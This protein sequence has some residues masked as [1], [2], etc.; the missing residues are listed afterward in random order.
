M[1]DTDEAASPDAE[2]ATQ[3]VDNTALP[4]LADIQQERDEKLT[5]LAGGDSPE[6]EEEDDTSED[7]VEDSEE[8]DEDVKD[9]KESA[10][11]VLSKE[12]FDA[13]S[14]EDKEAHLTELKEVTGAAFGKQRK[15]IRELKQELEAEKE[16]NKAT[17]AVASTSDSPFGN[18]HTVEQVDSS[19]TAVEENIEKYRDQMTY[20]SVDQ[21]SEKLE[22]D[23]RGIMVNG[24]FVSSEK[25]KS[26]VQEQREGITKLK[27]RKTEIRKVAKLFDDEDTEIETLKQSLNMSEEEAAAFE[28]HIA[29]PSFAVIKSVRPEYAKKLFDI[30]A[31]ASI[32]D[33]KPKTRKAPKAQNESASLPKGSN[34]SPKS[35]TSQI[36][37]LEDIISGKT[38]ASLPDRIK[39]DKKVRALKR[40]GK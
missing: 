20:D 32:A 19:I 25:L 7:V 24:Q 8:E 22:K 17:T 26:W 11:K 29:D 31:K 30:L 10:D 14:D 1:T 15:Q 5:A 9:E 36:Q 35:I 27:E 23:E 21:Y 40:K 28:A 33:R 2:E 3:E 37:K 13:L 6:A 16:L 38:K 12:Y 39:A 18:V 4:T 34:T